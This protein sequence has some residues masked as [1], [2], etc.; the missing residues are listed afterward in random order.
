MRSV[1]DFQPTSIVG[2]AQMEVA[3]DGRP[4]N[5]AA[6]MV[7]RTEVAGGLVEIYGSA[8]GAM[9]G[10]ANVLSSEER[11]RVLRYR[12]RV[13]REQSLTAW[14]LARLIL[15]QHIDSDARDL[16]FER[17]C[18]VCGRNGH[19]KPVLACGEPWEISL[20]HADDHVL[21]AV[22]NVGPVG[23]DLDATSD[24]LV[25]I[26]DVICAPTEYAETSDLLLRLWVRKEAVLKATGHGLSIPMASFSV[27]PLSWPANQPM[28]DR[29]TL[30]NIAAPIGHAAAVAVLLPSGVVPSGQSLRFV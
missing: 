14:T 29:L 24:K 30:A 3:V 2:I 8:V 25:E 9:S 15:A 18:R 19:G 1:G 23:V 12:R 21:V 4:W 28:S 16:R 13:D 11:E 6:H 26:A 17:H 10:Y 5:P 7:A 20:S 27:D 22:S